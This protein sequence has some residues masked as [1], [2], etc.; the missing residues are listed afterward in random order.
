MFFRWIF[1]FPGAAVITG[2]LFLAMAWMIKQEAPPVDPTAGPE[3]SI[4]AK[5]K[6]SDPREKM[7]TPPRKDLSKS[8]ETKIDLPQKSGPVG[9]IEIGVLPGPKKG[10]GPISLPTV[11]SPTVRIPPAYPE[12]CA[13]RG[14]EGVVVVEFDVTPEGSVA[15]PRIVSSSNSCFDR[16]VIRAIVNWKY[17]PQTDSDGRPTMRR[18]VRE[19]LVFELTE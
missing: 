13:T 4:T 17:S 8:P 9:P 18:G 10:E 3:I 6:P 16:A 19:T 11:L 7:K 2:L 1:G 12:S 15:D 14:V 5:L